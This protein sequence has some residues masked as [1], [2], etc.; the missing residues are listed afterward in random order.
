MTP[1]ELKKLRKNNGLSVTQ[2][3]RLVHVS[4]RTWQ[5]YESGKM[6]IPGAVVELFKIKIE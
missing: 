5:R 4:D 3:A 2:A 6:P 1:D